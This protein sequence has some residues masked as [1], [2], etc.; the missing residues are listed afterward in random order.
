[1]WAV[2][3][4]LPMPR[5]P[6]CRTIQTRS[7]S[8]RQTSTKW[9]PLPRLPNCAAIVAVWRSVSSEAEPGGRP[10][11][12]SAGGTSSSERSC[13]LPTPAGIRSRS[14]PCSVVEVVRQLGGAQVGLCRHHAAAD[15]DPDRRRQE[16]VLGRHD[17]ADG[18]AEAEVRVRHEA[19][20][21]G[22]DRQPRRP[23]RLLQ[24][25]V[26]ELA[27]PRG[28]V[29]G[30]LLRHRLRFPYRLDT[31]ATK[32]CARL[33]RMTDECASRKSLRDVQRLERGPGDGP[34][35]SRWRVSNSRAPAYEAGAQPPEHH[36]RGT[37]DTIRTC[38]TLGLG[39]LPLPLGLQGP[40][41]RGLGC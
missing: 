14:K 32:Q 9:L 37:P 26:V 30:D 4:W 12:S 15:V 11:A 31:L 33:G 5:L 39:Q 21:T 36:R 3:S 10:R 28:Q 20:R 38:N 24:G 25:V 6:E 8:S 27:G 41:G 2:A 13:P 19:D 18:R 35:E 22:Q 23:Q 40:D 7:R 34:G 29:R 1:M 16:G 17:A